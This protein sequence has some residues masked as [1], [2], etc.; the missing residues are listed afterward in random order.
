MGNGLY[1]DSSGKLGE[2]LDK[3]PSL[4]L[5]TVAV[6]GF[7]AYIL[8]SQLDFYNRDSLFSVSLE[9]HILALQATIVLVF[10]YIVEFLH[11]KKK[12]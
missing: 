8:Y 6:L 9:P 7:D 5:I 4:D 2:M 12:K 10:V 3:M 11:D 1:D